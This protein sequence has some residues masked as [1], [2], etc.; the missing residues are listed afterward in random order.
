MTKAEKGR[1]LTKSKDVE[2]EDGVDYDELRV[3]S[4]TL[5]SCED[6]GSLESLTFTQ[7]HKE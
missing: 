2:G 5:A 4:T 7:V 6:L 1:W 3:E